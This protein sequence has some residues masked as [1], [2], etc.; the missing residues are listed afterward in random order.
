MSGGSCARRRLVDPTAPA[1][2][3]ERKV[4][5]ASWKSEAR[6]TELRECVNRELESLGRGKQ[7]KAITIRFKKQGDSIRLFI[8][9]LPAP[10]CATQWFNAQP[11][12]AEG[13]GWNKL[14]LKL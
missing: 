1:R 13:A 7:L 8:D 3:A 9:A 10:A 14:E 5:A 11:V 2:E 6:L 4:S 12:P